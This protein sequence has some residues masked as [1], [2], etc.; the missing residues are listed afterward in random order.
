[1][2]DERKTAI[3]RAVVQEYIETAQPVGSGHVAA[4]PGVQVS[5]ATV[6]NEMAVLEQEGYLVQPHTSAGRIPTD[7]G[8]RFFVDHLSTPGVLDD[9]RRQ[10]VGAFFET[11]RGA[12]EGLLRRTSQLLTDLT[13][14]ASVVVGPSQER[15]TVRSVQVVGL[16][17]RHATVVVVVANGAVANE[18]LDLPVGMHDAKVSDAK[19]SAAGAHLA[20][21]LVGFALS[22]DRSVPPT[23]DTIVDDLCAG[24]LVALAEHMNDAA[25]PVFVRGASAMATAFDAVGTVREVLTALEQQLVVVSL[26]HDV[27]DRGLSVAIGAEHGVEPLVSCSVVLA[28]V[29]AEGEQVGTVGVVG[30]TRMNYP[31]A[32]AAVDVVSERL[33]RRL[34]E[35]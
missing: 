18:P 29:V 28:P 26:V 10:Q 22:S 3:L 6:R 16:S 31:K 1:M 5:P 33:G 7:K 35:G 25:S 24:A 15:A 8:Y 32:L 17:P 4:A 14:Y 13:S 21:S 2:L 23:G 19:V 9:V 20:A 30:P 34:E 12:L 27:L 11:S